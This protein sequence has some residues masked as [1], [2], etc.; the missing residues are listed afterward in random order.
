MQPIYGTWRARPELRNKNRSW[1]VDETY[2]RVGGK[3]TYCRSTLTRIRHI[4]RSWPN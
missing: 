2:C 3:W 4:R 1:R